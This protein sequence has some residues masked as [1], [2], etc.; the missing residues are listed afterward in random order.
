[1]KYEYRKVIQFAKTKTVLHG[2]GGCAIMIDRDWSD[3][4]LFRMKYL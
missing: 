3:F 4:I 2:G 1:M